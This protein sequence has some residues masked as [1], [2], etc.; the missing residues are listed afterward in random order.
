MIKNNY[1]RYNSQDDNIAVCAAP[2]GSKVLQS[3]SKFHRT[4]FRNGSTIVAT[5]SVIDMDT[6]KILE[7]DDPFRNKTLVWPKSSKR[8]NN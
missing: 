3:E 6:K 8:I 7:S 5:T 1:N 4:H 2:S